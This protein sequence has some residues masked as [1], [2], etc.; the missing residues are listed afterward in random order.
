MIRVK[1]SRHAEAVRSRLRRLPFVA[2]E[3]VDA[4]LKRDATGF[5]KEFQDGIDNASLGLK[6]LSPT[7]IRQ[8]VRQ[9]KPSPPSPLYGEG[10]REDNSFRNLFGIRKTGKGWKA[11][12]RKAKHHEADLS[13]EELFYIHEKGAV[14]DNGRA[15]IV[16]PPRPA[17]HISYLKYMARRR[18]EEPVRKVRDSIARA[19]MLGDFEY[20]RRILRPIFKA[21][22]V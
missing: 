11:V 15:V 3:Y 21:H 16:I 2:G 14:I 4:A 13:L 1:Y 10:D 12:P 5:I 18:K 19:M 9:G 6:A 7:T 22:V 20:G 8:K 17:G